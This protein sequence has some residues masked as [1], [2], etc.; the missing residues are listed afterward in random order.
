MARFDNWSQEDL[1]WKCR[2]LCD[3]IEKLEHQLKECKLENSSLKFK[4]DTELE[5]RLRAERASYDAWVT[6]PER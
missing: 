4:I 3:E 2:E 5:P 1:V 6:N